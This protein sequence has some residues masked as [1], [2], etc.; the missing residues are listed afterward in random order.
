MSSTQNKKGRISGYVKHLRWKTKE[1]KISFQPHPKI[2]V[3]VTKML[4]LSH[5]VTDYNIKNNKNVYNSNV[6]KTKC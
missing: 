2:L 5:Y 4:K 3:Y 6:Q 1:E